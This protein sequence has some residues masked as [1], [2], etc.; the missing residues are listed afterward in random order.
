MALLVAGCAARKGEAP[1]PSVVRPSGP[2]I[3]AAPMENLSNDLDASEIIRN[4]FVE[5]A[6]GLGWNVMPPAESDRIL[7]ET[8][9]I[10]YGGQLG[11]TNP[12]EVC[13]ALGVEGV[14]YGDV[15]EWIKTTTGIYNAVSV[16]AEFRLYGKGGDLLWK[17]GDR[18]F[19]N[20][21]PQVGGG[22][23]LGVDIL[24]HAIGNLF[25]NPMTPYGVAVGKNI[26]RQMPAGALSGAAGGQR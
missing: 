2:L 20:R 6:A 5:E 3:A 23:D 8:L 17:G 4:A 25:L 21:V 9:G 14:V 15:L 7:R 24:A 12:A 19:R 13:K 18:Q 11:A 22:R 1:P 16:R 26:A 10:S